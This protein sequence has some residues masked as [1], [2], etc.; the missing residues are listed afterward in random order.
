MD[1]LDRFALDDTATTPIAAEVG[2]GDAG[3]DCTDRL[4]VCSEEGRQAVVR[5]HLRDIARIASR[6]RVVVEEQSRQA[7]RLQLVGDITVPPSAGD[8]VRPVRPLL[9]SVSVY[10]VELG[11]VFR[12]AR[13]RVDVQA[14][15]G[16]ACQDCA[17]AP[18]LNSR[19]ELFE[20]PLGIL[21]DEV[22]FAEDHHTALSDKECELAG[23]VSRERHLTHLLPASSS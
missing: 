3:V 4:K 5:L 15:E 7:G 9:L 12:L 21:I 10:E 6:L 2:L 20:L 19:S 23:I 11:V 18:M 1:V 17:R 16:A 22:L 14:T 13:R 8:R